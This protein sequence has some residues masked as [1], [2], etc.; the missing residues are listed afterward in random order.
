M[1]NVKIKGN[2]SGTGNL[3]IEAPNTNTDRT[4]TLPDGSGELIQADSSGNVGIGT[5]SPYKS[6]TVGNTDASAWITSGGS[7]VHLTVSPNGA[8]G[9]FIV[10]TGGTN[11]DPSTTTERMRIDSSGRVTMPY[12]PA[13]FAYGEISGSLNL[14]NATYYNQ[15]NCFNTSTGVFTAPVSGFYMFA[16]E[17]TTDDADSHWIKMVING[18]QFLGLT[19]SYGGGDTVDAMTM[20]RG[21]P[22]SAND[23]VSFERRGTTY[24]GYNNSPYIMGYLVG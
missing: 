6:L 10:R 4:I 22:V 23:T 3:T 9:S 18:S 8:S 2:A 21:V 19:L 7:N 24:V 12:Q 1:S 15:G 20:T 14:G 11:G 17:Y 13:F 16:V 5:S